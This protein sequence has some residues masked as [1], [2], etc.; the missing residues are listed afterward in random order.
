MEGGR[1]WPGLGCWLSCVPVLHF[2][3]CPAETKQVSLA[4]GAGDNRQTGPKPLLISPPPDI[5]SSTAT[6]LGTTAE[7]SQQF[8]SFCEY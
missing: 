4:S 8:S 7:I 1:G 6:D 5:T 3:L 2:L